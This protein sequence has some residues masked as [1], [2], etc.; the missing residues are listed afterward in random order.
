MCLV[1]CTISDG[2]D[3]RERVARFST[4]EGREEEVVVSADQVGD[5]S[6]PAFEI[7]REEGKVLVELSRETSS[8]RWRVWL[9]ADQIRS[10]GQ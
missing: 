8:G 9:K 4:F 3:T 5:D 7:G 10:S 1:K 2:L 6:F